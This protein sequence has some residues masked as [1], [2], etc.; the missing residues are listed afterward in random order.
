M[1]QASSSITVTEVEEALA[2]MSQGVSSLA[3]SI[4]RSSFPGSAL[5]KRNG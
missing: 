1:S 4:P 3:I 5:S 2:T